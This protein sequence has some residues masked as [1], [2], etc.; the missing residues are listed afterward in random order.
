M[1]ASILFFFAVFFLAYHYDGNEQAVGRFPQSVSIKR[2]SGQKEELLKTAESLKKSSQDVIRLLA[3]EEESILTTDG[4][5]KRLKAITLACQSVSTIKG[6]IGRVDEAKLAE[7]SALRTAFV[8]IHNGK[9]KITRECN[10]LGEYY[11]IFGNNL[12]AKSSYNQ[13]VRISDDLSLDAKETIDSMRQLI[14]TLKR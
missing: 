13:L 6:L 5:A 8:T 14:A 1:K 9:S 7:D 10:A 11:E 4:V 3:I 12:Y 2:L